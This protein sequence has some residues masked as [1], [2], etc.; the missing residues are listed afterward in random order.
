MKSCVP[1]P[2]PQ[3]KDI[4]S[5]KK[6]T[7]RCLTSFFIKEMQ[8]KTSMSYNFTPIKMAGTKTQIIT[9]IDKDVGKLELSYTT[10]M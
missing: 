5:A 10:G 9:S 1:L 7:K 4:Q 8:T 3:K 6:H 2:A